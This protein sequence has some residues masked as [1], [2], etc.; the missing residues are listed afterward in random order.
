MDS[1][2]YQ[3]LRSKI[4]GACQHLKAKVQALV[5]VGIKE[6]PE[7]YLDNDGVPYAHRILGTTRLH[8]I[9]Q[10]PHFCFTSDQ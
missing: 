5:D 2:V 9:K 6:N 8:N 10:E 7:L 4:P 1:D 3:S